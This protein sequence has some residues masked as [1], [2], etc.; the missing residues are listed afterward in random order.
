[1]TAHEYTEI[2]VIELEALLDHVLQ[3]ATQNHKLHQN[4]NE[5]AGEFKAC[6][7]LDCAEALELLQ[8]WGRV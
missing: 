5:G 6:T 7:R 4:W 3:R 1:M 8:L 2:R